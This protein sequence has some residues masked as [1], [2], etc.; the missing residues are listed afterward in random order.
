M[1]K[2]CLQA[3]VF[4][5]FVTPGFFV[6]AWGFSQYY[7]LLPF[8]ALP[9]VLAFSYPFI[10]K[11]VMN[12]ENLFLFWAIRGFAV[13]FLL[14]LFLFV[15]VSLVYL[16]P[17]P[18]S[19]EIFVLIFLVSSAILYI[20]H[21]YN[22]G[23]SLNEKRVFLYLENKIARELRL[24]KLGFFISQYIKSALGVE[25]ILILV[26]DEYNTNFKY[27]MGEKRF[28]N[29]K[30]LGMNM[31]LEVVSFCQDYEKGDIL[32]EEDLRNVCEKVD[33][34]AKKKIQE[35]IESMVRD[36]VKIVVPL[37]R[38][39]VVNG[40][41]L[42]GERELN[43]PFVSEDL[44]LLE[45]I[46]QVASVAFGRAILYQ[47]VEELSKN[48]QRKVE[49]KT[50]HL[51]SKIEKM[52]EMRQRERDLIDIMGHELRTP[53]TI[54][55]NSIEII[56]TQKGK[57]DN[58][59][60]EH[61]QY[62]K[63]A[64]RREMGIVEMLLAATKLDSGQIEPNFKKV[65]LVEIAKNSKLAF[66]KEASIKSLKFKIN[67]DEEKEWYVKADS[68]RLQQVFDNF[69]SN[70]VKYTNKGHVK[71]VLKDLGSEIGV[72][73]EDTGEGLEEGDLK[74]LGEKFYRAGQYIGDSASKSDIVRPGGAGL[75]LYVAFGLVSLMNGR[76]E[77]ESEKGKG[78]IFK[79]FF[80]KYKD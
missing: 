49:E 78:S 42:I 65:S 3:L 53:L 56:E 68:L 54:A 8:L 67:F 80:E 7:E 4:M 40:V 29:V 58:D 69:V 39:L 60:E 41:I 50:K 27:K 21:K 32:M 31:L 76:Y 48:L 43:E 36:D 34:K 63:S 17:L 28:K 55:K 47:E 73:V 59:A 26:F 20:T 37:N 19:N 13:F 61:F 35:V 23:G 33:G 52:E 64:I 79:V 14:L 24:G 62:L 15:S 12:A 45:R 51:K 57:L 66:E 10:Q 25:N 38:K 18:F 71:I 74:R 30:K 2:N 75:G 11:K 46:A 5:G 9:F 77:I 72:F 16:E 22:E 44:K 1:V 6:L 70:A